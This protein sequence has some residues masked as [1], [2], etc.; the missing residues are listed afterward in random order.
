[1]KNIIKVSETKDYFE[2]N[3]EP[4]FYFADTVW[5]AFYNV[6]L[7]EWAEYLD[8]RKAQG[9]NVLQIII[10]PIKHDASASNISIEPFHVKEDG[11]YNFYEINEDYF[12]R[13]CEMLDM[14]VE[15]DF[16][17]ALAPLWFC[18]VITG[19]DPDS[20]MPLDTV[21]DYITYIVKT[22]EKYNPIYIV[23]GDTWFQK[24]EYK[25]YWIE[26]ETIK[27]LCSDS[28][29]AMH[30]NPHT[31]IP[32]EFL[33]SPLVD[34]VLY[35]SGHGIDNGIETQ[36]LPYKFAE[37]Y[38][39]KPVKRP[40]VNGEPC[41]E[42]AG[43]AYKYGR[44]K[45]FDVRKAIW[46][47]LLSGAKAGVTYGAHGIWSWHKKGSYYSGI[48]F[49]GTPYDWRTALRFK[50]A[51]DTAYAKW[52]FETY[53]LFDLEPVN[54][55][56]NK[57]EEIRMSI[58]KDR[59]KMVIYAPFNVDIELDVDISEYNFILFDLENRWV[60]KPEICSKDGKS[61]ITMHSF[62]SDVLIIGTK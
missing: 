32:E 41:Y 4:F 62:N 35:Q 1:M 3:R 25:F 26:I 50:G 53:K 42:G 14:A 20:V 24:E 27:A 21:K 45:E 16:V 51:W 23:S 18:H 15:R 7:E 61:T 47:S 56:L 30:L 17:P 46:Q 37:Y 40:I 44:F 48:E 38:Y 34:I 49:I 52:I 60:A 33:A 36:E 43:Y 31:N 59:N 55:V 10:L 5:S 12:E 22:F 2:K 8:Y 58:S 54:C 57:T 28:L 6:P 19:K 29:T 13:A 11:N 39:S 9:F